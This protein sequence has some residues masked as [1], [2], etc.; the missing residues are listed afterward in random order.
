MITEPF[1]LTPYLVGAT[2]HRQLY[3]H[4]IMPMHFPQYMTVTLSAASRSLFTFAHPILA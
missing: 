2:A 1:S 3:L 4:V